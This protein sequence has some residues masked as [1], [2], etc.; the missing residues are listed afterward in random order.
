MLQSRGSLEELLD[1][2]NVCEDEEYLPIQ[3]IEICQAGGL[4][5]PSS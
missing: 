5:C 4:A 2:L 1:D 3:E